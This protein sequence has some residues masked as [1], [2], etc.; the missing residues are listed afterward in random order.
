MDLL[1]DRRP[2]VVEGGN[3]FCRAH[4]AGDPWTPVLGAFG[5]RSVGKLPRN[6]FE[7]LICLEKGRLFGGVVRRLGGSGPGLACR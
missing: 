2:T 5:Q 6:V 1:F 7:F 3:W 4:L